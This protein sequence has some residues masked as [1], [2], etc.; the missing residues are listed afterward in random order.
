MKTVRTRIKEA[1][2]TIPEFLDYTKA[3]GR[4]AA[5]RLIK[6][7][8]YVCIDKFL[9]EETDEPNFGVAPIN[10]PVLN[11]RPADV[12]LFQKYAKKVAVLRALASARAEG[13]KLDREIEDLEAQFLKEWE[14]LSMSRNYEPCEVRIRI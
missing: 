4:W 10:R 12:Q 5:M 3:N 9:K 2:Y 14:L 8:D 7:K 6:I 11:N 1:G 13:K